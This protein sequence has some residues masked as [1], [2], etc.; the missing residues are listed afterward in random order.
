[1]TNVWL[2]VIAVAVLVMAV[3]Q[4]VAVVVVVPDPDNFLPWAKEN[5]HGE[6]L[7][8]ACAKKEVKDFFM[9]E[10]NKAAKEH[11]LK[12]FE[13]ARAIHIEPV[14][15]SVEN[16]LLT[17]TFKAKRPQLKERY[18]KEIDAMYKELDAQEAAKKQ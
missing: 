2:G 12:G 6:D 18:Q 15:F 17:P 14:P 7:A 10:L 13:M 9:S 5:G 11:K 16:D 3:V 1:V 4:V 8:A